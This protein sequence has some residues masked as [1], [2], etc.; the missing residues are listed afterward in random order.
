MQPPKVGRERKDYCILRSFIVL[1]TTN[2][3]AR[4]QFEKSL[5]K[6]ISV[7]LIVIDFLSSL[8]Y[9][10]IERLMLKGRENTGEVNDISPC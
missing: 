1:I 6:S 3:N 9:N 2:W 7:M 4:N 10:Q 8:C 5:I